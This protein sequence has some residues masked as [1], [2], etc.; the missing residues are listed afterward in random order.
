MSRDG[1]GPSADARAKAAETKRQN[2]AHRRSALAEVLALIE[3]QLGAGAL[4]PEE[5]SHD[6]LRERAGLTN[7]TYWRYLNADPD[8]ALKAA[9]LAWTTRPDRSGD[10]LIAGK[11]PA[12]KLDDGEQEARAEVA[13]LTVINLNLMQQ[14]AACKAMISLLESDLRAKSKEASG[15]DFDL[16]SERQ[17]STR[18]AEKLAVMVERCHAAGIDV[19]PDLSSLIK[20]PARNGGRLQ[21]QQQEAAVA[22]ARRKAPTLSVVRSDDDAGNS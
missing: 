6:F 17:I 14:V 21:V 18:L 2:A 19:D 3:L 9:A 22:R 5:I 1:R 4:K 11:P 20:P 10:K 15:K 16:A 8:I 13:R 12:G 7:A